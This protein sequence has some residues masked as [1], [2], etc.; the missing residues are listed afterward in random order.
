MLTELGVIHESNVESPLI[1][2]PPVYGN[3]YSQVEYRDE[4]P[5]ASDD[6]IIWLQTGIGK[7]GYIGLAVDHLILPAVSKLASAQRAPTQQTMKDMRR[8]LQYVATHPNPML[9]YRKGS[10]QLVAHT[11][12]SFMSESRCRSRT[13]DYLYLSANGPSSIAEHPDINGAVI[14][15]S[16]I[17][18]LTVP[19][20]MEGEYIGIYNGVLKAINIRET[21]KN[22][23][24]PQ[25]QPTVIV[26]DN[27][28]AVS[29]ANRQC[30]IKKSKSA[31]MRYYIIQDEI[32]KCTINV[33][34]R[35][36]IDK[37]TGNPTNLADA[38]TKAHPVYY[39]KKI[40]SYYTH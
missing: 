28:A 14:C 26:C 16:T 18:P 24:Y 7:L 17:I 8:L 37:S 1:Y 38:F 31:A 21:L 32:D 35:P 20:V 39:F 36:G 11:D 27:Q 19:S 5:P 23:G 33:T 15:T 10:M 29:V 6:D 4:S 12:A 2:T 22:I 9:V 13:A 30:A 3:K 25:K 34:W 40:R